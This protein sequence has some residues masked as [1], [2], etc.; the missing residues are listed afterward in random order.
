MSANLYA[1]G[2]RFVYLVHPVMPLWLHSQSRGHVLQAD[3]IPA[4]VLGGARQPLLV[5]AIICKAA[6]RTCVCANSLCVRKN[7]WVCAQNV[8]S[9][10]ESYIAVPLLR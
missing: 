9:L 4:L 3:A 8:A 5:G 1:V 6:L 2:P 10:E 7:M